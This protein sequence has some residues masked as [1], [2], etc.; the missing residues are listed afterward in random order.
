MK[1]K[2]WESFDEVVADISDGATIMCSVGALREHPK[3]YFVLF[4]IR[5]RK[6]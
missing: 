1:D 2:I 6:N 3:T 4:K 5:G